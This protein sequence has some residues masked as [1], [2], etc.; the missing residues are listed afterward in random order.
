M[1]KSRKRPD[2]TVTRN[3]TNSQRI[4]VFEFDS[5]VFISHKSASKMPDYE[6]ESKITLKNAVLH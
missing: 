4:L 1:M 5:F 2:A 6:M 3:D